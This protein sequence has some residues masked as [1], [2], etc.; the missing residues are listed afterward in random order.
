[1]PVFS[2]CWQ[3]CSSDEDAA[4]NPEEDIN[5]LTIAHPESARG[6]GG[7][8]PPAAVPR[9]PGSQTGP[10]TNFDPA[11]ALGPL[12][13]VVYG[14]WERES[15]KPPWTITCQNH[16]PPGSSAAQE[17]QQP[18]VLKA[19]VP[20]QEGR[21]DNDELPPAA[22]PP[23]RAGC[24]HGR[25]VPHQPGT[26]H[27]VPK[28]ETRPATRRAPPLRAPHQGA[29]SV[30]PAHSALPRDSGPGPGGKMPPFMG[31]GYSTKGARVL[32]VP[33]DRPSVAT[34]ERGPCSRR[35]AS[36]VRIH[37][38]HQNRKGRMMLQPTCTAGVTR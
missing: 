4:S 27:Q 33:T 14:R 21:S 15:T 30:R 31:R 28:R 23:P 32:C 10:N 13:S 12:Q 17:D 36:S 34:R 19:A 6:R 1:M 7:I 2:F 38:P 22:G 29:S 9:A 5:T 24:A 20:A 37:H 8:P 11:P 25:Y 3:T 16:R 18:A 26:K 35:G